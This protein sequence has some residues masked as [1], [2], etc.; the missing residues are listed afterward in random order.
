MVVWGQCCW[1]DG[2]GQHRAEVSPGLAPMQR[3]WGEVGK[4]AAQWFPDAGEHP[5][6]PGIQIPWP[7]PPGGPSS[8][9]W[10]LD[11][12]G[13]RVNKLLPHS[14]HGQPHGGPKVSSQA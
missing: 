11:P 6:H 7:P 9:A 10:G 1:G 13:Q 12:G 14:G 3:V 5:T 2:L 4:E 8:G